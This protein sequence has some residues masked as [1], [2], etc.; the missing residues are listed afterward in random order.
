VQNLA[1][2]DSLIGG[3]TDKAK[4]LDFSLL[5]EFVGVNCKLII[6]HHNSD[7]NKFEILLTDT[8]IQKKKCSKM[9]I[10]KCLSYT[11]NRHP[12]NGQQEGQAQPIPN[13]FFHDAAE[14]Q[15]Y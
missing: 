10:M 1:V 11:V 13:L 14:W 5:N 4:V 6:N 7:F 12:S 15:N 3:T 2:K 9:S 8:A